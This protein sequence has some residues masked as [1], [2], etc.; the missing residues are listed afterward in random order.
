MGSTSGLFPDGRNSTSAIA[1]VDA[2]AIAVASM[3]PSLAEAAA[4]AA[5]GVGGGG[6]FRPFASVR[7]VVLG[8]SLALVRPSPPSR[9]L[10]TCFL[11]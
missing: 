9:V 7:G 6:V 4:A 2:V 3:R 8:E 11:C 10:R 1:A 5:A